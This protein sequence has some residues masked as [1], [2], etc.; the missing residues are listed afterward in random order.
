MLLRHF[1]EPLTNTQTNEVLQERKSA[2]QNALRN[3]SRKKS[4]AAY[5][6]LQYK[7][8]DTMLE[9][10]T[11]G[12]ELEMTELINEAL[13]LI[14]DSL[15]APA[16]LKSTVRADAELIKE[17]LISHSRLTSYAVGSEDE[18]RTIATL[19]R[20][21]MTGATAADDVRRLPTRAL[22]CLK[23]MYRLRERGERVTTS[24]MRERLQAQEP[25][26][27]L[28][29]A[30][31]TQL[32]KSLAEQGYVN[33]KPYRGVE[34]TPKGAEAAAE[35]V[36]HHRLLE[37]YLVRHLGYSWDEVDAEAERL[38]H[39]ISEH[40]EDR[41]DALLGHPTEDPHGDPIPSK[42]GKIVTQQT[43]PLSALKPGD[44]AIVRRVSDDNADML[45]YLASLQLVPGAQVTL[46]ERTPFGGPLRLRIENAGTV[47]EYA[48]GSELADT[49]QVVVANS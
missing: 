17:Q 19:V 12:D 48:V 11:L 26:G 39:A 30:T 20:D 31:V 35:L 13:A 33:Y 34:L 18:G 23:Y 32:F 45:R 8:A 49:V 24:A 43:Q 46:L 5:A 44:Q 4:P 1:Q 2:Y 9:L 29:D 28:S 7:L 16:A 10:I 3:T 41:L 14:N 27:Q 42:S 38:E 36:R 21:P 15:D 40:F 47:T 22:D 25:D 37:L 6:T